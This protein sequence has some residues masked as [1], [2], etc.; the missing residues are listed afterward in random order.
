M[1]LRDK[2]ANAGGDVSEERHIIYQS[3]NNM[4][5]RRGGRLATETDSAAEGL[6]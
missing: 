4:D 2:R 1:Q 5:G 3:V 6:R